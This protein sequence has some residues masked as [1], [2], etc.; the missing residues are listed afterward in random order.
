MLRTYDVHKH[1]RSVPEEL[2]DLSAF[3]GQR[4]LAVF[5]IQTIFSLS[6]IKVVETAEAAGI[7]MH[8]SRTV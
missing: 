4:H 7:K 5:V 8:L 3:D 6:V 2:R 1:E